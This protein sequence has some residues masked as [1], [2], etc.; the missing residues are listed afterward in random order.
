MLAIFLKWE[1]HL[2]ILLDWW[3][4]CLK[5]GDIWIFSPDSSFILILTTNPVI[6]SFPF[7]LKNIFK[8]HIVFLTHSKNGNFWK[9]LAHVFFI[10]L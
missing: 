3:H 9:M 5:K 2:E 8:S 4:F 6:K 10:E 7:L 1:K